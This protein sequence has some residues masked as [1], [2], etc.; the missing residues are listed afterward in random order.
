MEL[1]FVFFVVFIVYGF[2]K[3]FM[4]IVSDWS[5]V[6]IFLVFGLVFIVIVNLLM[7]FVLF[8]I[9]GI[10]IMFVLLFLNGWF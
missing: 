9:L 1:G 5:N 3:F 10:G 7:G 8:F 2:S 4:G 6:W